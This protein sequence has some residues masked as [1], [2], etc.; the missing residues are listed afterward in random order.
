MY[1]YAHTSNGDNKKEWQLLIDHLKNVA[2]YSEKFASSFGSG[3]LA[4][5]AGLLHDLG[6]YSKEFQSRLEGS[7]E[8]VDHST[9]GAIEVEK[10]F[11]IIGRVLAYVIAG[12]HGG[13]PN[14]NRGKDRNLLPRL[15]KEDIKDYSYY[16]KEFEIPNIQKSDL[17]TIPMPKSLNTDAFSRSFFIRILYS[18][19]VDADFLDTEKFMSFDRFKYRETKLIDGLYSNFQSTLT[20]LEEKSR[21]NPST[22]NIARSEILNRCIKMADGK[23]GFYTLTV[24]TGGGK[25]YSS[26]AFALKHARINKKDRIIYVIPYTSIIEQN[27][28]VFRKAVGN[29]NVL[30]HHSNYDYPD[31]SF[32]TWNNDDKKHRLATENWDMPLIV[33]TSVQF[34]ESMFSNKSSKCRKLHNIANSVVILDEA[35]MMPIDYLRPCLYALS[36][37]ISNY[38]VTVILCTA[39]QPSIDKLVPDNTKITEIVDNQEELNMIFKRVNIHYVGNKSDD[40][41]SLELSRLEQVLCIVNTRRHAKELFEKLYEFRKE[42][43]YHLS[44]RMCPTHRKDVLSEIRKRLEENKE[45]RV[46]STQLIEAGVDIDFPVVY[47]SMAGIDSIAQA[48]GRCNREG[49]KES[50]MVYVF[51]PEAH[52]MP[53]KGSFELN[54]STTRST[55]RKYG[56]D[57]LSLEAIKYYFEELYDYKREQLDS[58]GILEDINEGKEKLLF[59]FEDISKKFNII[60]NDMVTVIVPFDEAAKQLIYEMEKSKYPGMYARSLQKYSVQIYPFEKD[61]LVKAGAINKEKTGGIYWVINDGSFYDF[62]M[63]LK[64]AKDVKAP[65]EILVY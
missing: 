17:L 24:P 39:T 40:E 1:F 50:G 51:E 57:I 5:V 10:R 44:A 7:N 59:P 43:T 27:A 61:A 19:I 58:K 45:C 33:T 65:D 60:E 29:E 41:I 12:H 37:L 49:K 20:M 14:G 47:R 26:L 3:R 15:E 11:G 36:E 64:D 31:G 46:V 30:E 22:I 48:S 55:R 54:A 21:K 42:G 53:K 38:N 6:K 4:Y 32:D 52:G 62:V 63:G 28:D 8:K 18:C 56:D 34:F 16:E 9:A 2:E 23:S 35:Q 25:T 13:L